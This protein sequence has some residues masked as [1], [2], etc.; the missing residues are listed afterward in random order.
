MKKKLPV[1]TSDFKKLIKNNFYYIDKSLFIKDILDIGSEVILIPR[2]RRFGKTLNISMLKYY[3]EK[4]NED[5]SELFKELLIWKEGTEYTDKQG[6]YPVIFLTFKDANGDSWKGCYGY[7]KNIISEEYIRHQYLLESDAIN[8]FEKNVYR[9]IIAGTAYEEHY[10]DSLKKLSKYLSKYYNEKVIILID[11]YDVP[12]QQGYLNG[13]YEK[14]IGFM[15]SLLSGG[16]KDNSFLE[17]GVLTGILRV[18]KE[19]IQ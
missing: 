16:L 7:I 1:G 6:K 13:Y 11:E 9:E 4:S 3:F 10:G 8:E 18:A 19:S 17:K 15:R 2:P 12:I 14:I 5:N